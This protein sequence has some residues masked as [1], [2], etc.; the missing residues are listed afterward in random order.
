MREGAYGSHPP[1][2]AKARNTPLPMRGS[3]VRPVTLRAQRAVSPRRPEGTTSMTPICLCARRSET[4]TTRRNEGYD[5]HG[6]AG[7][8]STTAGRNHT[9]TP[10]VANPQGTPGEQGAPRRHNRETGKPTREA[11]G[12]RSPGR[13]RRKTH[14][15][16]P[17]SGQRTDGGSTPG[18][19]HRQPSG[20]WGSGVRRM[21]VHGAGHRR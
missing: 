9:R 3:E 1:I 12:A 8:R 20:E 17:G 2:Q 19:A 4:P 18:P 16:T 11:G 7:R 21:P 14:S 13:R 10:K 5:A 6:P 15:R